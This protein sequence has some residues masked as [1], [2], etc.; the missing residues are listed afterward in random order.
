MQ[1]AFVKNCTGIDPSMVVN[2][3]E[4]EH[5]QLPILEGGHT[6]LNCAEFSERC[7]PTR[8][9]ML[10]IQYTNHFDPS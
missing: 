5:D 3:I 8:Q 7:V 4:L 6:L 1:L 10:N 9:L 2:E